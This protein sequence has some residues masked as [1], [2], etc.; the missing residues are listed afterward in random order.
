MT[1]QKKEV[2]KLEYQRRADFGPAQLMVEWNQLV[3]TKG[4]QFANKFRWNANQLIAG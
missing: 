4:G 2:R 3:S 1:L